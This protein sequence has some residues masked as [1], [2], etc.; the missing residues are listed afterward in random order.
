MEQAAE[1]YTKSGLTGEE[2]KSEPTMVWG[3]LS[4]PLCS[5]PAFLEMSFLPTPLSA[6]INL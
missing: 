4:I 2:I 3:K 1:N 5:H 6:F